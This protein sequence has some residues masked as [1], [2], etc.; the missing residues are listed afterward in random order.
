MRFRDL[1]FLV[2]SNLRR[3]KLRLALTS[4]GVVIGTSAI[5]LMVSLGIGL[6][7]N[8]TSSLGD[9]GAATHISVMPGGAMGPG[10]AES[11]QLDDKAVERLA[12]LEH[13]EAVMPT[14]YVGTLQGVRYKRYETY[15]MVMGAPMDAFE[16]F[17]YE[18]ESGRLPRTDSE[19]LLGAQV[20]TSFMTGGDG[21]GGGTPARIEL[22]LQGK[23][24]DATLMEW[25][26]EQEL[27]ENPM[28]EGTERKA[29][30]TV[31]GIL[32]PTD[33]Q[34]DQSMYVT[35]DT[36]LEMNNVDRRK[37][38][39]ESL[40]VKVDSTKNVTPVEQAITDLGYFPFS[41]QS[42]L[43]ELNTVF[44]IIQGVLGALGA[45]AMLV[46][47][48]G[49]ANTMTMSIYERTREIG[50]MKAVGASNRQVKRVFLGE[51]AIIGVLGGL[52]GLTF[53]WA[54]AALAN[55]FVRSMIAANAGSTGATM[56][57][58]SAFFQIPVWLAVF[59]IGF[60]AGIGL[61]AG[62][63]PAVRAA[64]LDPLTALRHE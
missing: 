29:R 15:P 53:S 37:M 7:D 62:V 64:N 21:M 10:M 45:I 4:L 28:A 56:P 22:D 47:A 49:I 60:A 9:L 33:M 36:A 39:Y 3:M 14:M 61:L 26:S 2:V 5:V 48:L 1:A 54:G 38:S 18:L 41:S 63:L 57:E 51:A 6:Q 46:A 12:A 52:G 20:P 23:R 8:L 25:P 24:L 50:I 27:A 16:A 43:E 55:L 19:V 31:V 42:M 11:G 17:G 44:L 59:A 32:K 58:T 13:V 35:L 40:V 34:T 30:L